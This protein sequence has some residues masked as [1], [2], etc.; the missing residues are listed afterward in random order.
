MKTYRPTKDT[1]ISNVVVKELNAK[2]NLNSFSEYSSQPGTDGKRIYKADLYRRSYG[3]SP[4]QT[5]VGHGTCGPVNE[6]F[7]ETIQLEF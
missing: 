7:V 5:I 2:V 6:S 4:V 1:P 3:D